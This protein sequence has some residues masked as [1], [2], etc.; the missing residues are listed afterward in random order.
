MNTLLL[1]L[2]LIVVLAGICAWAGVSRYNTIQRLRHNVLALDADI[3]TAL[4]HRRDLIHRGRILTKDYQDHEARMAEIKG[5]E[6]QI[7]LPNMGKHSAP[8]IIANNSAD[9]KA[10]ESQSKVQHD[11]NH[12]EAYLHEKI[13]RQHLAVRTFRDYIEV[14]PNNLMRQYAKASE[15]EFFTF[16]EEKSL[17]DIDHSVGSGPGQLTMIEVGATG[18]KKP[19]AIGPAST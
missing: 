11:L 7:I 14:F 19:S 2:L 13:E 9:T 1:F 10:D 5:P 18:E 3:N 4:G 12:V 8:P 17:Y 16:R 15:I 6:A